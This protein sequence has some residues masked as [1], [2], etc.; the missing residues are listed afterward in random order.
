VGQDAK[1]TDLESVGEQDAAY[2]EHPTP[3]HHDHHPSE[4]SSEFE[5]EIAKQLIQHSQGGRETSGLKMVGAHDERSPSLDFGVAVP[6]RNGDHRPTDPS[7]QP[8]E[9]NSCTISQE[10]ISDTHYAPI[11]IPP[12]LGQICR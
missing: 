2:Q 7:V 11:T 6:E 12:A 4:R 9:E 8:Q 10:R 5:Y 1:M 3:E